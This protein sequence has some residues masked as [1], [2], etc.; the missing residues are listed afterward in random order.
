LN[1]RATST[2][3]ANQ[4]LNLNLNIELDVCLLSNCCYDVL[5][6]H[7]LINYKSKNNLTYE[8]IEKWSLNLIIMTQNEN[9]TLISPTNN[10]KK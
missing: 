3:K 1:L 2:T 6:G 9:N 8:I 5:N 7:Y 10:N 4:S